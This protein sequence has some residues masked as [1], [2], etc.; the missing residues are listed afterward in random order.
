MCVPLFLPLCRVL[1]HRRRSCV[2]MIHK[3]E[4]FLRIIKRPAEGNPRTGRHPGCSF[5]SE[6]ANTS[7][8][9]SY[10]LAASDHL[11]RKTDGAAYAGQPGCFVGGA[12]A[13]F[14]SPVIHATIPR[15]QTGTATA[16]EF[17]MGGLSCSSG[18]IAFSASISCAASDSSAIARVLRFFPNKAPD[19]FSAACC[20]KEP[21]QKKIVHLRDA[22][23][24]A[25]S[26]SQIT[27]RVTGWS[28]MGTGGSGP[29]LPA[30][31]EKERQQQRGLVP[32]VGK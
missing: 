26:Q 18:H 20:S 22:H 15:G 6:N 10:L 32:I 8:F 11:Q 23:K 1:L 21:S 2:H 31:W 3:F 28:L 19:P 25:A 5:S 13:L 27:T 12:V 29:R 30:S 14:G 4:I 16:G 9:P 17:H 24:R 7:T